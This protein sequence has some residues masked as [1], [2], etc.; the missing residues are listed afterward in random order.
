VEYTLPKNSNIFAREYKLYLPSKT[1]F[2][3]Q[4]QKAEK[5]FLDNQK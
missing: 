1:E 3:K 5:S 4:I 2:K